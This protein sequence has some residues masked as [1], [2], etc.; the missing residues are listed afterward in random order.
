MFPFKLGDTYPT[1]LGS[2]FVEVVVH[3]LGLK[4]TC[5]HS[6]A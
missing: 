4:R 2:Y 3:K 1:G 5:Y 6:D